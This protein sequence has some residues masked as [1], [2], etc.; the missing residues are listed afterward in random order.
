M[1]QENI[2]RSI[3]KLDVLRFGFFGLAVMGLSI[4]MTSLV[5]RE[6]PSKANETFFVNSTNDVDDGSCDV[7]H[8]S[9]REALNG[10]N[11]KV[12]DVGPDRIYFEMSGSAPHEISFTKP[13]PI[14]TDPVVIDAT[15]NPDFEGK[16]VVVLS[17]DG[18]LSNGLVITAG[19]SVV[20]GFV[21]QNF[22]GS[23]IILTGHG[24][25]RVLANYI[26]TDASGT[27]SASNTIGIEI[28][29]SSGNMIGGSATDTRNVIAGCSQ[30]SIVVRGSSAIENTII[31]N[32]IA[33]SAAG[34]PLPSPAGILVEASSRTIIGGLTTGERNVFYD[35]G[36]SIVYEAGAE[37]TTD[38]REN[39]FIAP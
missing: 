27:R 10:A 5:S 16:P 24:G 38:V 13:L 20:K 23:G 35:N 19:E 14:I 2:K 29:D 26:C 17:G 28:D 34:V 7:A 36:Q 33:I 18:A 3:F 30:A 39:D 12:N 9:F 4:F 11:L 31:G 37:A 8:C 22:R 1:R 25:D 21:I 6:V 15:T 32:E